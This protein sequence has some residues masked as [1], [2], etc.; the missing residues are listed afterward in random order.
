MQ[1]TKFQKNMHENKKDRK[2]IL[3]L[4]VFVDAASFSLVGFVLLLDLLK[5]HPCIP[6]AKDFGNLLGEDI[7]ILFYIS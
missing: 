7:V 3:V 4:Y 1:N 6:Q 2:K 5:F